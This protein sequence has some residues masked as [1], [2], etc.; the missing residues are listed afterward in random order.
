[1]SMTVFAI[2]AAGVIGMQKGAIQSNVD[3]RRLDTANGIARKWVERLRRDSM[4]WTLPDAKHTSVNNLSDA[5]HLATIDGQWHRPT[6]RLVETPPQSP[7]FDVLGQDL[8]SDDLKDAVFCTNVRLTWLVPNELIRAEIRV[9]WPRGISVA[10]DPDF[11]T[12]EPSGSLATEQKKYRF[13][14]AVTA[15][16]KN[17]IP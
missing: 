4:I 9:F 5:K 13:V 17:A 8:K 11:C 12:G 16:R 3:A 14:Y 7:G 15:I 2:G 1:M 10:A 6:G